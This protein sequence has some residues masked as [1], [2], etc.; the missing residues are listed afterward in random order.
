MPTRSEVIQRRRGEVCALG[1]LLRAVE[2]N[3]ERASAI[4]RQHYE[5][6]VSALRR[7]Q[8]AETR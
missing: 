7:L 5:K 2:A 1:R 6:A 4:A 3:P 8:Q